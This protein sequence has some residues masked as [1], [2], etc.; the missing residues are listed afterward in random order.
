MR[1]GGGL[2]DVNDALKLPTMLMSRPTTTMT[3]MTKTTMERRE[4]A[5]RREEVWQHDEQGRQ[6]VKTTNYIDV[7]TD[8]RA[9]GGGAA[10]GE[11]RGA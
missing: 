3:M 7:K 2:N 8:D 11:G 1:R 10:A 5:W 6:C 9:A 4:E